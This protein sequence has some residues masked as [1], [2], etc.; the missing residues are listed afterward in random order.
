[1][2]AGPAPRP[3]RL[4][5]AAA[6][7]AALAAGLAWTNPGPAEFEAFAGDQLVSLL[8]E[9]LCRNGGLP[10]SVQVLLRD[11]PGLI[12]SQRSVL[13]RLAGRGTRRINGGLF[14]LYVSELGG[15]VVLPGLR[16]PRLRA[17]TLAGAGQF[18]V[19]RTGVDGS[20]QER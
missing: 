6:A 5:P 3:S 7:L 4:L 2:P 8:S 10:L 1:L 11:C 20:L 17:L 19:L 16:I 14:S 13:A 15:Q 9:E 18:T 12:S